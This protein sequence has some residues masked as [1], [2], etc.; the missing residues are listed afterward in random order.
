AVQH[1]PYLDFRAYKVGT[2]IP[3]AMQA[4]EPLQY[5]YLMEKNGKEKTFKDYPSDTTYTFKEMRLLNPEA[6]AKITDYNLWNNDGDF[7]EESFLGTKLAIIM[8]DTDKTDTESLED[9]RALIQELPSN[10]EPVIFTST[11]GEKFDRFVQKE[12]LNVPFYFADATVL[13]TIIRSNPGLVLI[14]EGNVR[15]KWHFND[16]P[17]ADELQRLAAR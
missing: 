7:T 9:I 16:T 12:K 1:L 4:S 14:D 17:G 6:Q 3:A 10:I 5:E 8:Y 11:S 13:K 2:N 15:G